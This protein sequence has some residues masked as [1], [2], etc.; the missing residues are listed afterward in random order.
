MITRRSFLQAALATATAPAF[1][2]Y[3][4]LMPMSRAARASVLPAIPVRFGLPRVSLGVASATLEYQ[5]YYFEA[6]LLVSPVKIVHQ[7]GFQYQAADIELLVPPNAA[8]DQLYV[9][10]KELSLRDLPHSIESSLHGPLVLHIPRLDLTPYG[11]RLPDFTA[12]K[13]HG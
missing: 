11:N 13:I 2:R 12:E 3:G 4:S 1:V 10:G 6:D 7:S 5:A 8:L 9:D